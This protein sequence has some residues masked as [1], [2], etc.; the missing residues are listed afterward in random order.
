MTLGPKKLT[1]IKFLKT[2]TLMSIFGWIV[3]KAYNETG[4]YTT[5]LF[6]FIY[7][8][9]IIQTLSNE[10]IAWL[11]KSAEKDVQDLINE[12]ISKEIRKQ[13]SEKEISND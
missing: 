8:G 3:Y 1:A 7:L 5:L 2:L 10:M 9:I 4:F 13:L 6:A 11:L 12:E